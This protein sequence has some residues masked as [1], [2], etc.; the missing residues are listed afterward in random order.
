MIM[1]NLVLGSILIAVG[2]TCILIANVVLLIITILIKR[3]E[4]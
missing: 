3:K 4:F 2:L 1:N